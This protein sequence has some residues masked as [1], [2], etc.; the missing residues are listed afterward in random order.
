[1]A[2]EAGVHLVAIG[3]LERENYSA[4]QL[5]AVAEAGEIVL[6]QDGAALVRFGSPDGL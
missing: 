1:L 4:S 2:E 6:D 3:S 5:R